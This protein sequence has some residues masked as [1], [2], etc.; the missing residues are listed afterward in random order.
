M[1]KKTSKNLNRQARQT[2]VRKKV[3]GT[4]ARPD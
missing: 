4:P 1:I 3:S 2:R